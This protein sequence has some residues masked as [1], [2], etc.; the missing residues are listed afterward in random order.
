MNKNKRTIMKQF[1]IGLLMVFT[2]MTGYSQ[3]SGTVIDEEANQPLPG[4]TV[5]IKGT[6]IG[7]TTDFDGFFSISE[8]KSGDTLVFTFIGFDAAE[9]EAY[10]GME[11]ILQTALNQLSEV[12][13]TSGVIDIAKVRETPVAVSAISVSEI[14]LKTGNLEFPEIMNKTPGVYA[15]KQGG[16]YGDSRIS[17]RGFDQRNTSFLINGQP[18]NDMENGW[19]YWSNWQGLT[20]VASGIQIQR[21]LGASRLAVP[22]VGG[23]VSIF[24]KAASKSQGGKVLQM[25]GNDGYKKTGVSY[26]TGKNEKGWA[27]SFLLS[28]WEGDGYV[29]NT[30]GEGYTYFAAVGYAPEGSAHELNFSFLGAGQWHHQRDVWVS[31]RDYQNFGSEGI[32]Q[33]WNSNGGTLNGEEFSMR[34]NFYN[35]PLATFNWDWEINSNLKLATSLYGSAGRGGGTGP[36]GNNFRN[37]VSDILPFRKDLTEHYLEN[38]R[39]SRDAN[40]FIDFDAVVANNQATTEG[41]TGDIGGYEGLLIGSNGF[42]DSNVNREVLVRRASMNSHNWVGGISNLEGQFGKFKTSIGVDLRSYTGYHYRTLNHLMG[43]DGYYSTGN[44]NS[45]GQIIETTIEAS[46]FKNT[47]LNGPK[48]DYYNVGKVGWQG[49]NTMVEYGGDKLTAVVQAGLSNQAFQRIDYFDQ[50]GNPE[51]EVQNQ[52]GGYIKGGA[53]FNIDEKQ[54]V[55]F[56][57]GFISRQPQFG[58]VFP[59]YA[60]EINPDLQN[61]EITSFELGYGFAAND[62]SFNINAYTTTWGNRFVQRNLSNQQGVDGSAQFKNIDVVHNGIEFEGKYRLSNATKFKGM[63][64]IGDWRYT[65]DF[66][67]ELFDDQQQSIGTGTLYLKDA[68]VGDAAQFTANIGVDQK[69]TKNIS[70]DLDYRFVDGLYADYSIT[71]SEFTNPDNAGALKLPSYGLFDLGVTGKIGNGWTIRAN[72]N[73]LLD[74]TYIAESNSNIHASDA[75]TTWNGVDTRNSVWFGFGRTWNASLTYRF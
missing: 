68:K 6:Q 25:I 45:A 14:T 16:G 74:E 9:E 51:S 46:P 72:I 24:T 63:L 53:N 2:T 65:K 37:G 23:T 64:S 75:S 40:G 56:N 42:R 41:Y 60:N 62:F 3:I 29:Y 21:G 34:R 39:G 49:L 32:D 59:N 7:T 1:L 20:D 15:T 18:V 73:N 71:D 69:I 38:G 35:K 52:G 54:N 50:V 55:F 61:E 8:A 47:G 43:L 22:S 48:I 36:R 28:R 26:N 4:A 44:R 5:V 11:V 13:V 10:D 70:M 27:S 31:I 67:A 12:V 19:V 57:T 58:A 33:R 66:E 17:L 30:S